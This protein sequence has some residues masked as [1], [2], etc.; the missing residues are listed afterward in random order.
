M[1]LKIKTGYISPQSHIIFENYF[2]IT[3]ARIT[4]KLPDN[5]DDLFKN[6]RELPPEEFQFSIGKQ[7]K[8]PTDHSEGDR[9]VNNNLP[10][11]PSE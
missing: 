2:T 9:K 8:N 6:H 11:D 3:T 4:N 7:W 10:T 5:W 1:V